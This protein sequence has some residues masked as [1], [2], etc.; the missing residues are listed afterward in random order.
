MERDKGEY[1][2]LTNM[3]T[4]ATPME[5]LNSSLTE[6]ETLLELAKTLPATSSSLDRASHEIR[7][8]VDLYNCWS[9]TLTSSRAGQHLL[10]R[11]SVWAAQYQLALL[12]CQV[13]QWFVWLP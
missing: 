11:D 13:C 12:L 9:A 3:P 5:V 4:D 10:F 1:A 2:Q 6:A 7:R 8:C